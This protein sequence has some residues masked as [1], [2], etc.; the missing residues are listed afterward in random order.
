MQ[1]QKKNTNNVLYVEPCLS[2]AIIF[3]FFLI[4]SIPTLFIVLFS[5]ITYERVHIE[6]FRPKARDQ[7]WSD[8]HNLCDVHYS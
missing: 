2:N 1:I 4:P 7:G 3:H 5:L 6:P 8:P